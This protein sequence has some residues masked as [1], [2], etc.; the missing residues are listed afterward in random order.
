MANTKSLYALFYPGTC[1]YLNI[2]GSVQ[3]NTGFSTAGGMNRDE[4]EKWILG[5]NRFLGKS[6]VF[7][8]ELWGI[9]DGLLLLQKR[10]Q[11]T[12]FQEERWFIQHILKE[13]NHATDSLVK[14]VFA[15]E[16]ELCLFEAPPLEIQGNLEED[17]AKGSLFPSPTL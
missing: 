2:D 17:I 4:T 16:E 13:D 14:M 6:S 5:Y 11:H 7:V 10:I 12:L 9:F 1:V 3:M 8:A 15:N